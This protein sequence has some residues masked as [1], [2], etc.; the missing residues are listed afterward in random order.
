MATNSG[1][2]KTSGRIIGPYAEGSWNDPV[3]RREYFN[4]AGVNEEDITREKLEQLYKR[5]KVLRA[6]GTIK[7]A[8]GKPGKFHQD[9][10]D[11][12]ITIRTEINR[13]ENLLELEE[14]DIDMDSE[15]G[16]PAPKIS[17]LK[18]DQLGKQRGRRNKEKITESILQI[19]E[20]SNITLEHLITGTNEDEILSATRQALIEDD[21]AAIPNEYRSLSEELNTDLGIVYWKEKIIIPKSLRLWVLQTLHAGHA[22]QEKMKEEAKIVHWPAIETDIR[23]K[24]RDCPRCFQSGKSTKTIIPST[25][26]GKLEILSKEMEEIQIDFAG[27]YEK[28]DKRFLII[29]VDRYSKWTRAK[30][31]KNCSEKM[32]IK[33]LDEII[34]EN[35]YPKTK[36]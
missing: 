20:S 27:P 4:R 31:V 22:G 11:E 35:G 9:N 6:T 17:C 25:K 16:N 2:N 3:I 8:G 5:L 26:T 10:K 32:V 33:F 18:T 12:L 24:A 29:G 36:Q 30:L 7:I 14:D 23:E 15:L 1:Q 21:R 34:T 28:I 13:L 19:M